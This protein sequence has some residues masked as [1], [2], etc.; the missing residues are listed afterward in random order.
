LI[1]NLTPD[2]PI[3]IQCSILEL[4]CPLSGSIDVDISHSLYNQAPK[5]YFSMKISI[6]LNNS[7]HAKIIN[8][9]RHGSLAPLPLIA[10]KQEG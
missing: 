5:W 7:K 8:F 2:M 9:C 4:D 10:I 1:N 3:F 6:V